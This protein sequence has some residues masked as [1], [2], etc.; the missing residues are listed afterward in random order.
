MD[1]FVAEYGYIAFLLVFVVE[2]LIGK[3]KIKSSSTIELIINVLK[4]VFKIEDKK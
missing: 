2:F 3:S 4:F 1:K